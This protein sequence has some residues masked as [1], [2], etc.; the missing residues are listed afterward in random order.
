MGCVTTESLRTQESKFACFGVY[1]VFST[2]VFLSEVGKCQ[3]NYGGVANN[4][5]ATIGKI[6]LLD[7]ILKINIAYILV[8]L[9]DHSTTTHLASTSAPRASSRTMT[10]SP[11]CTERLARR[12]R[13]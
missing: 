2:V 4:F 1:Q 6:G 7:Q 5:T 3:Q 11:T 13:R 12:G 8:S 9:R 10:S